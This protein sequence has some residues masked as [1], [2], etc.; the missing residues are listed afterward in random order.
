MSNLDSIKNQIFATR[1]QFD[2]ETDHLGLSYIPWIPFVICLVSNAQ[3]HHDNRG[4]WKKYRVSNMTEEARS[5]WF[6]NCTYFNLWIMIVV[7][8]EFSCSKRLLESE[9]NNSNATIILFYFF[10]FCCNVFKMLNFHSCCN[11]YR[12]QCCSQK[13]AS[14][15]IKF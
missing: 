3:I 4:Y 14:M 9:T 7:V 10:N 11:V 6:M 13:Q 1:L 12:W 8:L 5:T 2:F 15:K